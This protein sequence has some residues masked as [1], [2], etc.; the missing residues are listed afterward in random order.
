MPYC[1]GQI[2]GGRWGACGSLRVANDPKSV[3]EAGDLSKVCKNSPVQHTSPKCEMKA[4]YIFLTLM[5]AFV[6]TLLAATSSAVARKPTIVVNL[7][8]I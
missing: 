5:R 6:F 2:K 4:S 7:A 8:T 3:V 1:G